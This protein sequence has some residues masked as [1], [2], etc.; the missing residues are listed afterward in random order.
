VFVL[1][2]RS[3][4]KHTIVWPPAPSYFNPESPEVVKLG[5]PTWR[6]AKEVFEQGLAKGDENRMH[7][8]SC[9]ELVAVF[10][11]T[12]KN[13]GSRHESE[14]KLKCHDGHDGHKDVYGRIDPNKPGPTM[15]TACINPSKGRFVHP[16]LDHGISARHAARFQGFPEN[17][18]FTGGLMA[19]GV[20][21]GNAVPIP[22]GEAVLRATLAG[23]SVP[24]SSSQAA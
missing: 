23:I 4:L 13:G 5:R 1:G 2:I 15:T 21:I 12:P 10:R 24:I 3:C 22:L 11:S 14:R 7:M 17:F 6:S 19:A 20:Q 18:V 9:E 16:T 8:Q